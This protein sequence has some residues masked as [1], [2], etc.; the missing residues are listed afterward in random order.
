MSTDSSIHDNGYIVLRNVLKSS[1]VDMALTCIQSDKSVN[2]H[3]MK[4]F[5]DT[6]FFP[7]IQQNTTIIKNPKYVKFRFSNNN[8]STDAS[9]F[10]SDVYNHTNSE[11]LPIYTCLCYFDDS[12]LEVIPG[13]HIASNKIS[14]LQSYS[15]KIII[16]VNRGDI[17]V[18][19]AN[20]HHRGVNFGASKDRRLL[21]VF[22][23]FPDANTCNTHFNNLI[24]V[25]SHNSPLM[26]IFN[27]VS[28]NAA[29]NPLIIDTISMFHYFLV[30]NDLQY[31]VVLMDL[32]PWIK[33]NKYITYEP[34]KRKH[35]NELTNNEELNINVL[36]DKN[37]ITENPSNFYLYI[38]ILYY[39]VFIAIY[40]IIKKQLY[41]PLFKSIGLQTN[42]FLRKR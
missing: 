30:Y 11:L 4:Q 12:Q 5:I 27:Y 16:N 2:Y 8:N 28:Y 20:L 6:C 32:A 40:Y 36:C 42:K 18:F 10:H 37:N 31:K 22:E 39:I 17:L 24:T 23:V 38:Y 1:H 26:K 3:I 29:R 25:L 7:T 15:N 41:A 21:Q 35:Y 13:S 34:G 33:C 19:H 14:S 9:T